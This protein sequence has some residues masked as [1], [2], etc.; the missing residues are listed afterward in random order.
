M[1][2]DLGRMSGGPQRGKIRLHSKSPATS[3]ARRES[4]SIISDS[5]VQQSSDGSGLRRISAPDGWFDIVT[6]DA[7]KYEI[8][9]YYPSGTPDPTSQTCYKTIVVEDP[10]AS[11]YSLTVVRIT[12]KDAALNTV[13]TSTYTWNESAQDWTLQK[14]SSIINE[15][16]QAGVAG[17]DRTVT[18]FTSEGVKA[19][20]TFHQFAWGDEKISEVLDPSG[21]NLVSTFSFYESESESEPEP[22]WGQ[23]A[24]ASFPGGRWECYKY[25]N[26]GRRVA[27]FRPYGDQ[28]APAAGTPPD[29]TGVTSRTTFGGSYWGSSS[30]PAE[31]WTET[32]GGDDE[33]HLTS[34]RIVFREN[35]T[36]TSE[37]RTTE[38]VF[39][40]AAAS[41]TDAG[42][43]K[44]VTTRKHPQAEFGGEIT[45]L[46]RANGTIEIRNYSIDASGMRTNVTRSGAPNFDGSDV[47]DGLRTTTI[48]DARGSVQ[49]ETTEDIASGLLLTWHST[50]DAD[51]F[52]RPLFIGYEDGSYETRV[53]DCCGLI[54]RSDRLGTVTTS[55]HDAGSKLL[56]FEWKNDITTSY[57]YNN[58][59]QRTVI[60]RTGSNSVPMV[61][62]TNTYSPDGRLRSTTDAVGRV[63]KFQ[64][65][66]G[67]STTTF[68]FGTPDAA[69]QIV[70]RF[71]DGQTKSISGSAVAPIHYELGFDS[72]YGP[73][74]L[75][76]REGEGGRTAKRFVDFMG[77]PYRV[78]LGSGGVL[79][80]FYNGRGQ[81]RRESDVDSVTT[82]YQYDARGRLE[83]TAR[84]IRELNDPPGD[85]INFGG[86]DRISHVVRSV[87]TRDNGAATVVV[88][89]ESTFCYPGDGYTAEILLR[90]DDSTPEGRLSWTTVFWDWAA[91]V[92]TKVETTRFGGWQS[93]TTVTRPNGTYSVDTKQQ[94]LL[95]RHEE[96]GTDGSSL[97]YVTFDRDS[98][99]RVIAQ[100]DSRTGTKS[101]SWTNA[102]QIETDWD[103]TGYVYDARGRVKQVTA[104]DGAITGTNYFPTGQIQSTSGGRTYP[105]SYTYTPQGMLKTMTTQRSGSSNDVTT[106][107]YDAVSGQLASKVYS[108]GRG[109]SYTYS[110]GGRLI[111]RT[112]ARGSRV[113]YDYNM[114]GEVTALRY[115]DGTPTVL[116][117]YDRQGRPATESSEVVGS[118]AWHRLYDGF[119]WEH[120]WDSTSVY[121]DQWSMV[122]NPSDSGVWYKATFSAGSGF[123]EHFHSYDW[124]SKQLVRSDATETQ[125]AFVI[126]NPLA[127]SSVGLYGGATYYYADQP[128]MTSTKVYD[129]RDRL[130][131]VSYQNLSGV[132]ISAAGYHY[133]LANQRD[134]LTL[135]DGTYWSFGYDGLGQVVSGQRKDTTNGAAIPG[136]NH[137]YQFDS[138]G[139]RLGSAVN[140]KFSAYSPNGL[141]QYT[142]RTN[143]GFVDV[144]GKANQSATVTV[145]G[146]ASARH[147]DWWWSAVPSDNS[148]GG[149]QVALTATAVRQFAGSNGEDVVEQSNGMSWQGPATEAFTYDLDGNLTSDGRW[150]YT[151]DGENRLIAL[152]GQSGTALANTRIE[153]HYDS[154]SRRLM[155]IFKS[156]S[157]GGASWQDDKRVHYHWDD[158]NLIAET[159]QLP[160]G[161]GNWGPIAFKRSYL[162]GP[163]LS[164]T[165]AG[166]GGVGGLMVFADYTPVATGGIPEGH[167]VLPDGNGNVTDLVNAV[168]TVQSAHYEYGP[169][170]ELLA[171][172]GAAAN[173]NPFRFSTK[174]DDGV[175]LVYYGYRY[176]N[177][178]SGRWLNRDPLNESGSVNLYGIVGND[179]VSRIDALGLELTPYTQPIEEIP[180]NAYGTMGMAGNHIGL[181]IPTFPTNIATARTN[182]FVASV[183]IKGKLSLQ[184]FYDARKIVNPSDVPTTRGAD[185]RFVRDHENIHG[186]IYI[187]WWNALKVAVDPLEL[188]FCSPRCAELAASLANQTARLYLFK[189]Q[190]ENIAFDRSAYQSP[191]N[192]T[193]AVALEPL[194]AAAQNSYDEALSAWL[195]SGCRQ[196][197]KTP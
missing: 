84:Q 196:K 149:N 100:S 159:E 95:V 74:N 192:D 131:G 85:E 142:Q 87:T 162:W 175:G 41:A 163:D 182:L 64:E 18:R 35:L 97:S 195:E 113:D 5:S 47:V 37:I 124:I 61:V 68:A 125:G 78:E 176:Y 194:L 77:R 122:N 127:Q 117:T 114:A 133:N 62:Q 4:L 191:Y 63:T 45:R 120:V 189:A 186:R 14:S 21:D 49:S 90:Q 11:T 19:V 156:R 9:C 102:D 170:G 153:H 86:S 83:Y 178:N 104:P 3:L 174:Y 92:T 34:K 48:L 54:F 75:E 10:N 1:S 22:G 65:L 89:R 60:S 147:G 168:T 140:G 160:T 177:P 190:R 138:I 172:A 179:P 145:N 193:R 129:A 167:F 30:A 2:I 79:T 82:L 70:T 152:Q 187:S 130:T 71:L 157:N 155:S 197:E 183:E 184:M 165:L 166:A 57:T 44:T 115:S 119:T 126:Y 106:W 109:P 134:Q 98:F 148:S 169:F 46:E 69:Q 13:M 116:F 67:S 151:W 135:G 40:S 20:A 31:T 107:N 137:A 128:K 144:V 73:W 38:I 111:S 24:R 146:T 12:E 99:G 15:T 59:G 180:L 139:N 143:P 27:T 185:G 55:A 72:T 39:S 154:Q 136:F 108:D 103:G 105:V 88:N 28:P 173:A 121:G 161:G 7:H 93:S 56:L 76:V 150:T 81:L 16:Q 58:A 25:D 164:N 110:S 51:A 96:Y 101:F 32:V 118:H 181:T 123:I 52:G 36:A 8:R 141:N 94:D 188:S 43:L 23:V 91:Q 42:N 33:A 50:I 132:S 6:I 66:G 171:T 29:G 53:Y 80:K 17:G 26:A 112:W 158:W